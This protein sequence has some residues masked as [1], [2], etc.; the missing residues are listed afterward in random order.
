V[1]IVGVF[2]L[3]LALIVS[4]LPVQIRPMAVGLT[5][6]ALLGLQV[7]SLATILHAYYL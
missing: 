5:L 4:K 6:A 7:V 3:G 2:G 1:T